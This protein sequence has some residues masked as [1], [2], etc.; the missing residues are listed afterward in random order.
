MSNRSYLALSPGVGDIPLAESS[1]DIP[2]FWQYLLASGTPKEDRSDHSLSSQLA[3]PLPEAIDRANLLL[4]F[5]AQHPAGQHLP[6][7]PG[8]AQVLKAYLHGLMTGFGADAELTGYFEEIGW[9]EDDY[10]D[11]D[12]F[13]YNAFTNR[14]ASRL[15]TEFLLAWQTI[16]AAIGKQDWQQFDQIIGMPAAIATAGQQWQYWQFSF[17][18]T[19]FD[20]AH[21]NRQFTDIFVQHCASSPSDD[22]QRANQ[23]DANIAGTPATTSEKMVSTLLWGLISGGIYWLLRDTDWLRFVPLLLGAFFCCAV[24]Y[25]PKEP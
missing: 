12:D 25:S 13:D 14:F 7:L 5:I 11:D 21:L 4:D 17:G 18:L 15:K 6:Y 8:H 10:K 20:D 16:E 24:W 2:L 1:N 22:P 3:V 9:L 23:Q 19:T